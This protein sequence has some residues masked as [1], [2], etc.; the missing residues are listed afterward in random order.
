MAE[1]EKGTD[2]FS[3]YFPSTSSIFSG[4]ASAAVP[5]S[6]TRPIS[7]VIPIGAAVSARI[8]ILSAFCLVLKKN[9]QEKQQLGGRIKELLWVYT[10]I[11]DN[12][13]L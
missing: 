1:L 10:N 12:F 6:A 11:S 7:A 2:G 9:K 3:D 4:I 13:L 5:A 8:P